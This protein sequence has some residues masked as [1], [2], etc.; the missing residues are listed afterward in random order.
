VIAF[1]NPGLGRKQEA[2]STLWAGVQILLPGETAP[3]HRHL[4]S[5]IRFI[6]QGKGAYT[7]VEGDP[8]FIGPGDLVLTP[9]W[10]WHDH[11]NASDEPVLWM[12][13]LDL[14]FVRDMD[15]NFFEPFA[16]E[17]QS[18]TK[19]TN[20][21]ER[22]YGV[23]QLRPTWE[24][25]A[26][27]SSPLLNYKWE[28]TEEVLRQLATSGASPFDDV[29]LEYINRHTGGPALPTMACWIQLIRSGVH[30]QGASADE[31][32]RLSRFPGRGLYDR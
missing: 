25:A 30:N 9:P 20:D 16:G 12:D 14:P 24:H 28:R 22:R 4:P 23:A 6:I 1:M 15:A 32:R 8:C 11:G 29:A 10:T 5:A 13:G 18:L 7:T 21:S 31:Q 3:A 2:T 27:P 19:S 17:Q 26:G